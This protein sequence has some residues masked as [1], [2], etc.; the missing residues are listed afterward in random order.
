MREKTINAKTGL[1]AILGDPISHSLS[2]V[3][4]NSEFDRRDMDC[5]FLALK[6]REGDMDMV[7]K[8]LRLFGLKGYVF[9]MPVKEAAVPY[10]DELKAEAEIIQAVNC[11]KSVDGRLVGY[12]T[13]SLG[14]WRAVQSHNHQKKAVRKAFVLGMGGFAKAAVAQLALQGVGE[15]VVANR[16]EETAY[17]ESFGRFIER[18]K[19]WVPEVQVRCLDWDPQ[20]W[21]Q[22]L[23]DV[24]LI[25]NGTSNGMYGS[26]DLGT[27]FPYDHVAEDAVFFDAVYAP[28]VTEFLKNAKAR[29]HQTVEGLELLVYQGICSFQIWTGLEAEAGAMRENALRFLQGTR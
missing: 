28:L 2:P 24:D 3:I 16:L 18:L 27:M 5:A 13:D 19:N 17:V 8:A 23:G 11:A 1:Y 20:E 7:M 6:S 15:I 4:M 12:N 9:T 25:A 10:M 26:G 29:G 21:K 22:E 14:F